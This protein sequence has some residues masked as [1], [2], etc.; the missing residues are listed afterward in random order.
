MK[1]TTLILCAAAI[2]SVAFF[3]SCGSKDPKSTGLEFM[4]DMYRSPSLEVYGKSNL[5]ADSL[6]MRKPVAGTISRDFATFD[7]PESNEGYEAA[8]RDVKNPFEASSVNVVEGKRLYEI[9]CTHCHGAKGQGDGS[10]VAIGKFPPPPSY[11]TGNSSRGGAMKDLTDG[12]IYHTITYGLNL[13]GP[14]AA[15]LL[16][17]ERW[18]IVLWVRDLQRGGTAAPATTADSTTT[19]GS[20]T[21]MA[22]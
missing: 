19:S 14:H 4:P 9:Y 17:D 8:G 12:K 1:T 15:Q 2:S 13:M 21:A 16:P 11:S 5:F 20:A 10:I 6:A 7:Y 18:K 22:K 3:S